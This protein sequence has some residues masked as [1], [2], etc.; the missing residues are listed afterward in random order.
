M[1]RAVRSARR[2][3]PPRGSPP[4]PG[5]RVHGGAAPAAVRGAPDRAPSPPRCLRRTR[6]SAY[7]CWRRLPRRPCAPV[8]LAHQGNANG[9]S[10]T[11]HPTTAARGVLDGPDEPRRTPP[12][13]ILFEA[14]RR[15][16]ASPRGGAVETVYGA[17]ATAL[18]VRAGRRRAAGRAG[19]GHRARAEGRRRLATRV[20]AVG[21]GTYA[22]SVAAAGARVLAGDVE[23]RAC[24]RAGAVMARRG[25]RNASAAGISPAA[26]IS[27]S[28]PRGAARH[29]SSTTYD[30]RPRRPPARRLDVR[31]PRRRAL[32][33]ERAD[34]AMA[35]Y[36]A[37]VR[38]GEHVP[39]TPS[40]PACRATRLGV[41]I[42][43][44]R[45]SPGRGPRLLDRRHDDPDRSARRKASPRRRSSSPAGV[46][47]RRRRCA[48]RLDGRRARAR[49]AKSPAGAPPASAD[50]TVDRDGRGPRTEVP[51]WSP[52]VSSLLP[53]LPCCCWR[54][55][56]SSA[57]CTI[58][59]PGAPTAPRSATPVDPAD[60]TVAESYC[61]R[62]ASRPTS[63]IASPGVEPQLTRSSARTRP[64]ATTSRACSGDAGAARGC[65]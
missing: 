15:S 43:P 49:M 14:R 29:G 6:G 11:G 21:D 42:R 5:W 54:A 53:S 23:V 7:D 35:R 32:Y 39:P 37:H 28:S 8:E 24:P 9:L 1:T 13:S 56:T 46:Q 50:A 51:A 38:A 33:A 12:T 58:D 19:L 64:A 44:M 62:T 61:T 2:A 18:R 40:C 30:G 17:H 63:T 55:A 34:P 4:S 22:P 57:A 10:F 59:A 31:E 25:A 47:C 26:P 48:V 52:L 20:T 27:T 41:D 45:A 3:R 16:R 36:G 65:D 60:A